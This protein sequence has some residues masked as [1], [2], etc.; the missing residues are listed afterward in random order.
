MPFRSS[1]CT[2]FGLKNISENAATRSIA[3]PNFFREL[4]T[5]LLL[6][7]SLVVSQSTIVVQVLPRLRQNVLAS[8]ERGNVHDDALSQRPQLI[9]I[10]LEVA[11]LARMLDERR[12]FLIVLEKVVS[13]NGSVDAK[14]ICES[15]LCSCLEVLGRSQLCFPPRRIT[16]DLLHRTEE[17]EHLSRCL[18]HWLRGSLLCC[19]SPVGLVARYDAR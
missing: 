10:A 1:L 14:L 18:D 7:L 19:A 13:S 2:Y 5:R 12:E 6:L 3:S 15:A 16:I 4:R 9:V 11:V 8:L 17:L